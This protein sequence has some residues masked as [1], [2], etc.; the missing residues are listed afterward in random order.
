MPRQKPIAPKT[1]TLN[2]TFPFL[3]LEESKGFQQQRAQT[4]PDCL[5]V[6]AFDPATD[7]QRGGSREGLS[8]YVSSQ[9]NSSNSIQD[10]NHIVTNYVVPSSGI[11]QFVYALTSGNGWGLGTAAGISYATGGAVA[12]YAFWC[13]CWDD[14]NNVYI[15][16]RRTSGGQTIIYKVDV[17]GTILWT[18]NSITTII[19]LN[20]NLSG[21]C[22]I[23]AYL[24]VAVN[25]NVT[26]TGKIYKLS[27][28]DGSINGGTYWKSNAE[29]SGLSFSANSVNCLG[30]IGSFLGVDCIGD[31]TNQSFK[32]FDTTTGTLLSS[33]LYGGTGN[34]SP[35]RVVS[36]GVSAFFAITSTTAASNL[37]RININGVIEWSSLAGNGTATGLAFDFSTGV[38]ICSQN[39][40]GGTPKGA[41]LLNI[42]TG[43]ITSEGN[44]GGLTSWNNVDCDGSGTFLFWRNS[45]AS[46]DIVATDEA[47]VTVWGPST[48]ANTTHLGAS[49]NKG[50]NPVLLSGLSPRQIRLL[51]VS[52]GTCKRVTSSAVNI[53]TGGSAFSLVAP[54]IFSAQNGLNM[55]YVD[56]VSYYKYSSALDQIMAWTASAGSMPVDTQG[57]RCRGIATYR[58][59]TILWG[60]PTDPGNCFM[61]AVNDPT[62]WDYSPTEI[63]PTQAI[64]LNTAG[65]GQSEDI[66]NCVFPLG[67]DA[68]VFGGD[69]TISV[70]SGDPMS[71]GQL[72]LITSAVGIAWGRPICMDQSGTVYFLSTRGAIYRMPKREPPVR[73]S[74]QITRRLESINMGTTICR[75]S[76]DDRRQRLY[77]FLTPLTSTTATTH[78]LWEA[79]TNAWFPFSFA[80]TNM[81]PKCIHVFDG[82]SPDD[83]VLLIGSWDGYARSVDAD[84]EDDDG[85]DID[86]SVFIGPIL[87]QDQQDVM[88]NEL[89]PILSSDAADVTMSVHVGRTAEEAAEADATFTGT[90][91][92]GRNFTELV[93]RSGH[94]IFVKLSSSERW[95]MEEIRALIEGNGMVR[96]RGE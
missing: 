18:Q 25:D 54:V 73:I 17:S 83:R 87:T 21:M 59:R 33:T 3:G 12:N 10:I 64:A 26:T 85:E 9:I 57:A 76:Y 40:G 88:L 38:L 8:K 28:A 95:A 82:D 46:N 45:Q 41:A 63:T 75:M 80:D 56:G 1:K 94:A 43:S 35:S 77:V 67:D 51:V 92:A 55:Y 4:T 44:P 65:S 39:G 11:G 30:S 58:G 24:Y 7:R 84:A 47:I 27:V 91:E 15:A 60:L 32:I 34:N 71:G 79:R 20:R 31:T 50:P 89:Q 14:S 6:V 42:M 22:V 13:S 48:F 19:G 70:M 72:D 2:L 16:E 93:R 37:K 68:A 53:L 69:H 52:G 5:N 23:G 78:F 29:V 96:R 81:N 90:W 36:N 49:V 74:Q 61:S 86:S 62:D 66:I